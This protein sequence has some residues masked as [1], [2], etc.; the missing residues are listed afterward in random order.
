MIDFHSHT[1]ISDGALI[2]SE[3]AGRAK[4][5]GYKGLAIT[6][7]ADTS[8]IEQVLEQVIKFCDSFNDFEDADAIKVVP[9]L[10]LT[11]VPPKLIGTLVEQARALGAGVVLVHGETMVEPVPRG[12]N[13]AAIEAC[14]DILAHPGL[15]TEEDAL[16]AK[17]NNVLFEIT[18]RHGHSFTNGHVGSMAKRIGVEMILNSD[19]HGPGDLITSE[20]AMNVVL[21]AGLN[22]NDFRRMEDNAQK[23]LDKVCP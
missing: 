7:H 9:G 15:V 1:L 3:L 16:L 17:K 19:A 8:N 11:H 18:T 12:T 14:V 22:E 2:A 6:D 5:I 4:A 23:L 20:K 13:R 21:G 10:E